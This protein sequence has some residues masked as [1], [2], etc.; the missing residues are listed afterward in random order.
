MCGIFGCLIP[1]AE[2][3]KKPDVE[4][5]IK[6]LFR[7]SETR[8]REASGFCVRTPSGILVHKVAEPSSCLLD[9]KEY[10]AYLDRGFQTIRDN[11]GYFAL[12]GHT[13]LATNGLQAIHTNNQPVIRDSTCTIHNGIIVNVDEVWGGEGSLQR[14][15]EIDSEL[16]P[17][18]LNDELQASGDIVKAVKRVYDKCYGAINTA[19]IFNDRP[20]LLL[21]TNVG[22]LYTVRGKTNDIF[23][24]ASERYI[25]KRL[26]D[27]TTSGLDPSTITRIHPGF[28]AI[29]ELKDLSY[30]AIDFYNNTKP[31]A[32]AVYARGESAKLVDS[33]IE[34]QELRKNLKR[35]TRCILPETFPFIEFD[36]KGVCNY[37]HTYKPISVSNPEQLIKDVASYPNSSP[38]ADCIVAF[39]GGRDSSYA[40]HYMAKELGLKPMAYTYDWGM[41]TDLGRRNQARLTGKL[42]LEHVLIS[43]NIQQKR[44]YIRSNLMAWLKKPDM[45]MI[46]LLMAGDKQFFY[47]ANLLKNQTGIGASVWSTNQLERT[48]FKIALCGIDMDQQKKEGKIS[49]MS[50]LNKARLAAYYGMRY[51]QNPA[52]INMSIWDT[53]K[54]Y[55]SYYVIDSNYMQFY[56]Y[57]PWN[58]DVI[59]Q[60]LFE[61][62]DWECAVDTD[63]TWRIGDGTA[64][65]YNYVYYHFAGF[66]EN[67]TFRSNQ[68]REGHIS[69]ERAIELAERD[70]L[71]RYQSMKEYFDLINVD[72]NYALKVVDNMPTL[73][74]YPD[75]LGESF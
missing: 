6:E 45:G 56:N 27:S 23:V 75:R 10:R 29:I 72:F 31:L 64:P 9:S 15:Y 38:D 51:I 21:A 32:P 13:R 8:G 17:A 26:C 4:S 44:Q 22:S 74:G 71:P 70:N 14:K 34:K 30:H 42:G 16:I 69:R 54:A 53:I 68:I 60:V 7:F 33:H 5:L 1:N 19:M 28:G 55:C 20:I 3:A 63:S 2:Y 41:I 52:Y 57:L 37:C 40:L 18:L 59:E 61:H 25:L 66:S 35:C 58:E 36:D 24:F 48:Q 73:Y 43:A 50:I 62:Y 11:K 65:F 46:P 39:S 12:I 49:H 67:D 47:Y